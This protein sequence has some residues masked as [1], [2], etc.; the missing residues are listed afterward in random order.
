MPE[1]HS[2]DVGR[3]NAYRLL[4]DCYQVPERLELENIGQLAAIVEWL[5]PEGAEAVQAMLEAWP[6]GE[7]AWE[8]MRVVHAKLFIGPFDL[9]APPYG[10][11]YLDE[12]RLVMGDTTMDAMNCYARAGLD[13]SREVHE[14]PDHITT[15]LEFMYYLAY[16]QV[17]QDDVL[18]LDLQREFL[19]NHLSR[20]VPSFSQRI[21]AADLGPFYT[22]LARVTAGF[23][24]A[25]VG[26]QGMETGAAA[27]SASL[28]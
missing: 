27:Q 23:I 24:H 18:Y 1:T 7:K 5:Y 2:R 13:P 8:D 14:P 4:A 17:T 16:Q 26:S 10:S 22:N 20:W 3:A 25:E 19:A 9:L 28:G 12:D 6:Q 11:V 21:V 15:E